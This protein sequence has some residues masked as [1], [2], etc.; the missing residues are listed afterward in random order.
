MHFGFFLLVRLSANWPKWRPRHP[1]N[2]GRGGTPPPERHQK[3]RGRPGDDDSD[4]DDYIRPLECPVTAPDD[5]SVL[6]EAF[7]KATALLRLVTV[8]LSAPVSK[9]QVHTVRREKSG[10]DVRGV[11]YSNSSR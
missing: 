11:T 1:K 8:S 5:V 4:E 2:N 9:Q 7:N 3:Q 10:E 6:V